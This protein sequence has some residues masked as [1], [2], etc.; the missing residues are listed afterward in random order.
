MIKRLA[1][2][3]AAAILP[4]RRS[5]RAG[6][7][8]PVPTVLAR[9]SLV[10]AASVALAVAASPGPAQATVPKS[11][12]R[13]DGV[14]GPSAAAASVSGW[15][16][17]PS[18]NP[19]A[20]NGLFG[21]TA[22]P[23]VSCPTTSV[24]TA[25]GLHVRE[26]GLGVTL[27]ERRSGGVWSVQSTPN[28]PSAAASALNGVSCPSSSACTAVG[29][30][31]AGSGAQLTL[32]ERWNGSNWRIQPTPNP[33]GSPSSTL[34]AVACPATDTCAAVGTSNSK[35]LVERW[36]GARWHLQSAPVP[37]G[38]QFSELNAVTCTAA[39]SCIAVGDYVNSSGADV[40]LAER[41]NGTKWAIQPTPNPSGA[42]S[43]S[44][45][46]GVSCTGRDAC[47]AS[48]ASDTGAFAERWN[49]TSWRLQAVPAPRGAQFAL[50][51]GVACAASSCE[52]VGGYVDSS[53]AFVTLGE[54]WNGTAWHAQPTPNPARASANYLSGVSCPLPSDCTAA[55]QGNGDGT[56][57]ALGER[58]RGG[59]WGIEAVPSPVGAAENQLNGIACPATDRCVAVGTAGPTRGVVSTE[60]L[61]WNGRTWHLQHI[62]ALPGFPGLNAVSCVSETDCV[63]VGGSNAGTLAERWN[64]ED[65][66]VQPT[67]NPAGAPAPAFNAISCASTSSCMAV[68][69]SNFPG[70]GGQFVVAERWNGH[71]WS[72]VPAPT[73]SSP[74]NSSFSGVSCPASSACIGVGGSFDASGNPT[75]TF[76]ERWNGTSWKLQPTPTHSA[77]GDIFGSVWCKSVTACIATGQANAGTLAEL[78]NGTTWS[79][80]ATPNPPGTQGNFLSSVSCTSLSACTG[81]GLA[82]GVPAGFPP[83]TLAERWNGAHWRI[84]PT[85]LLPAVHDISPLSVACPAQSSCIAVGGFENDGPGS[86]TLTEQW[87]GSGTPT[88]QTAPAVLSPRAYLGIYGCIRAAIG[89]RFPIGAAATRLGPKIQAPMPQRSQPASEIERICAALS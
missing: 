72:L 53:G 50:L 42:Q 89:E 79:V 6:R 33:A 25:V 11:G 46:T 35:L 70:G 34:F 1:G 18:P 56:P 87:R 44:V 54:R 78:L 30:F 73:P 51:F 40:S 66:T 80:L 20:G 65:W 85:P 15:S 64:G 17:T 8:A 69:T 77:P 12:G 22:G 57:I 3:I 27:A 28:P 29:Q 58:W 47:E 37:P 88:A 55:G 38:A 14:R 76:A 4:G 71:V 39:T 86:K 74:P 52:A 48:G 10:I 24:C 32:A 23:A 21:A 59:R 62:P 31:A 84:Q 16:I 41:W 13:I 5:R 45:L 9:A 82:F 83:Q 63:A 49:S 36:G 60:A 19:R 2:A 68:G 43:F 7:V 61:G 75:G 67:P 81:A 26:S